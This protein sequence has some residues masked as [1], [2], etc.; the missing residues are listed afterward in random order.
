MFTLMSRIGSFAEARNLEAVFP[1]GS[2]LEYKSQQQATG[3]SLSRE[4]LLEAHLPL[5]VLTGCNIVNDLFFQWLF[6]II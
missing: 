6:V 4:I 1:R 3:P 5:P 2:K